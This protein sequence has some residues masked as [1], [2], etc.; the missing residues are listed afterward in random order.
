MNFAL[1]AS[2]KVEA[3]IQE[4]MEAKTIRDGNDMV[5][6]QEEEEMYSAALSRVLEENPLVQGAGNIRVG[7]FIVRSLSPTILHHA[8]LIRK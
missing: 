4:M 8:R 2:L 5:N 7:E 3:Y 1:N 6:E